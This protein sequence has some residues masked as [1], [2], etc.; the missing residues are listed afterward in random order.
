MVYYFQS[1]AVDPPAFLYVG[2]DKEESKLHR[3]QCGSA[4]PLTEDADE[5]LIKF[6]WDED[7]W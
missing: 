4:H 5:D 6:G 7:V 1:T 2:K 3:D